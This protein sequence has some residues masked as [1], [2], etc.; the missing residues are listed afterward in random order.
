MLK[1]IV[2]DSVTAILGLIFLFGTVY[3][4]VLLFGSN[5]T[6]LAVIVPIVTLILLE[7]WYRNGNDQ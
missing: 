2:R 6:F 5:Y 3:G 7:R 1:E 4:L